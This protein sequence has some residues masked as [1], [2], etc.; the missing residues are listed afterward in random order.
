L[1]EDCPLPLTAHSPA[2]IEIFQAIIRHE[3]IEKVLER[4]PWTDVRVARLI[5]S[6]LGK[7]VFEAPSPGEM[8]ETYNLV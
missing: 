6:L 4:S 7:G 2:E 8:D 3:T 5:A 1:K